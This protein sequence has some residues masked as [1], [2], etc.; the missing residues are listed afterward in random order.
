MWLKTILCGILS[1]LMVIAPCARGA[2][3]TPPKVSEGDQVQ[4]Q[5]KA[6][7]ALVG[8]LQ[9]RMFRLAEMTRE[10]E[11]EDS[12][13][14]LMAVRRAREQLIVEQIKDVVE[15][16][17]KQDLGKAT[18]EQKQVLVKLEELKK[19]LLST[20]LD[21]AMQIARLRQLQ[22][23]IKKLDE[24]IKEEKRQE[25]QTGQIVQAPKTEP[26]KLDDSK[27]EQERNRA[28]T[29][30]VAQMA[31]DLGQYGSKAVPNLQA[32]SGSMSKAEGSL[33]AGQPKNAQGQQG[34]AV[35]SLLL[36]KGELEQARQKLLQ[37][38]EKQVR[39]QVMENLMAMLDQQK[40][41]RG[42]TEALASRV[43]NSE[44]EALLRVKQLAKA[45]QRVADVTEQTVQLIEETQFSV[46]LPP[47][48]KNIERRCIYVTADL[49]AGR[50][51]VEVVAS[52]KQIEQDIQELLET[53]KN[54][55]KAGTGNSQCKSCGGN[56]NKLLAELKVLRLLQ[57][58]VNQE[59]RDEDVLRAKVANLSA[60]LRDKIS[61]TR[62][63]EGQ[64]QD[65]TQKLHHMTCP[66]CLNE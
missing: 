30:A 24:N 43:Q 10:A 60:D 50:G 21:L 56:K 29:D 34:E 14:L 44:R 38:I 23:T 52:Q 31:K 51:G 7:G 32:G 54:S 55:Y 8:E 57:I 28:V 18:E 49:Q 41:V 9:E 1:G 59:T 62:D 64:V 40:A 13:K 35:A 3:N 16:L 12:A 42:A 4:F 6:V 5:Q 58:R 19:L 53:F 17:G 27:K 47:I 61:T 39:A 66:D 26:K 25:G 63:I 65:A 45:E 11:P 36:A 20:D 33:G 22:A 46:A 2:E 37:E 15:Q 48:L